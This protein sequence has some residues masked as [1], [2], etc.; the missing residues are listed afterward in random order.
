MSK[1]F[2]RDDDEASAAEDPTSRTPTRS[3]RARRTTSRRAGWRRM[4]DELAWLVKTERPQVTSRR[5]VGREERRSLRERRL[6]VRQEA[7]ARDRP[8]HPLPHQAPRGRRGGGPGHARGDRPGLLRRD[9]DL[10]L[11]RAARSSRSASSASTRPIPRSQLRELDLAGRA[12][13]DQGARGRHGEPPHARRRARSSRSSRCA[14]R[15]SPCKASSRCRARG[16]PTRG[17]RARNERAFGRAHSRR[18]AARPRRRSRLHACPGESFLAGARRLLRR[19]RALKLVVCRHEAGAANMA[20]AYGKLTGR[21]GHLLRDARARA[22]RRR[23]IGRAHRVPGFHADDPVHRRRGQRL[24]RPRGVPGGRLRRDVRAAR[25]VGGAHRRAPT[26]FPSTSRAPSRSRSRGAAARWC[27]RCP[28]TCSRATPRPCRRAA[29]RARREPHPGARRMERLREL[30]AAAKRPLVIAGRQRLDARG[31]QRHCSASSR[32]THLPCA[33]R[34]PLP[35]PLRQPPPELRGRRGHRHQPGARR[36]RA[37]ADLLVVVG[38]RLGEMT[39]SGYT[40]LRIARAAPE[41]RARAPGRRGD[42][43]RLPAGAGHR[44]GAWRRFAR[45]AAAMAPIENPPWKGAAAEARADFV[46]WSARREIA[47]RACRC[48]TWSTGSTARCPRT[49]SS[50]TAP[51]TSRTWLHRFHRYTGL[52]TQLAPTSGAMGYGVPAAIAAKIARPERTVVCF[53]GDGDFLMTGQ[54][55]ATAVQYDAAAIVVRREQRHVRHDP[56]APGEALSRARD[57]HRPR[58]PPLR[59]LRALLRRGGRDRRGHGAVRPGVRALP[60]LGQ[61]RR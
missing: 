8:A 46:A 51:A 42:R 57:R 56:H 48:G 59:R 45:A 5:L 13:A 6:P 32:R 12:R 14:T 21:P 9:G 22:P 39:T 24:P 2:T 1:A 28:R 11:R 58:Q 7:P 47:G 15:R 53:A 38:A 54:E 30:L 27:W 50:P 61:A 37:H 55:L 44:L 40:L 52:R 18:P 20:E 25:Q 16:R 29:V 35:G 43:A 41:A 3:R 49:R 26:A 60:G 36:A 23:P 17:G 19:A 4:R 10:R 33:L 34:L 31:V